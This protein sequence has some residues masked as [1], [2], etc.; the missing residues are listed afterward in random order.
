M[1]KLAA[2]RGELAIWTNLSSEVASTVEL[3]ALALEEGD[4]VLG[5]QLASDLKKYS[6]SVESLEFELQL[7][8]V[9]DA[10]PAFLTVTQGRRRSRRSRLG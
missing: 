1:R 9:N 6:K 4:D 5:T 2:V 8:G 7:G 3:F 10:R